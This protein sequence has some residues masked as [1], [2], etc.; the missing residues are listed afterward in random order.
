MHCGDGACRLRVATA[1]FNTADYPTVVVAT[2]EFTAVQ[3]AAIRGLKKVYAFATL[4]S[5]KK[6]DAFAAFTDVA[7]LTT[8]AAFI[9]PAI[10]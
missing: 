10:G 3:L 7:T 4:G 2:L 8:V 1:V 9:N 6:I 5:L